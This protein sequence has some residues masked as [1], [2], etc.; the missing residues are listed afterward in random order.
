VVTVAVGR[1]KATVEVYKTG[2]TYSFPCALVAEGVHCIS[3]MVAPACDRFVWSVYYVV[4]DD[5]V[6]ILYQGHGDARK[7]DGFR[8]AIWAPYG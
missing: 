1:I 3:G 7:L 2:M 5:K 6:E 8:S 4:W